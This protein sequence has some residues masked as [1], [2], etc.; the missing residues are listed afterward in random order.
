MFRCGRRIAD[1]TSGRVPLV[2]MLS[3]SLVH[4]QGPEAFVRQALAHGFS[5]A[6]VPDLPLE[7]SAD[8]GAVAGQHDFKVV[9]LVTPTTSPERAK[10]IAKRSTGFLYCVSVAGITGER[11]A[12]PAE[13][14]GQLH[15]LREQTTLPLCVGFGISTPEHVR[16]LRDHCDGIIVGSAFVRCLEAAGPTAEIQAKLSGLARTLRAALDEGN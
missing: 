5:G 9:H 8:F 10:Q 7:E 3:F 14:L 15:W 1:E 11:T 2:A 4:R 12:L 6:I 16:M 13:L